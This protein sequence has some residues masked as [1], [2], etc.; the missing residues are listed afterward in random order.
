MGANNRPPSIIIQDELH[1]ISGPLGS[2]VGHY[3]YLVREITKT[4]GFSPKIIAST[5]TIRN[6][7]EQVQSLFRSNASVF[8]PTGLEQ[9][10]N[11]FQLQMSLVMGGSTLRF[12]HHQLH[13]L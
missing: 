3:E 7:D 12:L 1:L 2:V 10:D 9:S 4:M 5:A 6:A 8:P 11:Y 13:Q